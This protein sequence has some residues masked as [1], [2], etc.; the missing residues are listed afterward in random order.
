MATAFIVV[1]LVA[2]AFAR[3][4]TVG[5]TITLEV[6]GATMAGTAID[7]PAGAVVLLISGSGPTDRNGNSR[8]TKNDAMQLIAEGLAARGYASLRYDKRFSG[9]TKLA[10]R[11]ES[12]VTLDRYAE[13]AGFWL[14][15]ALRRYPG[16]PVLPLGHSEGGAVA[17]RLSQL[18]HVDGLVLIAV[19]GR[20]LD[21][22]VIQQMEAAGASAGTISVLGDRLSALR[23]G[24]QIAEVP[25]TLKALLRPGVYPFWRSMLAFDAPTALSGFAGPALLVYGERDLQVSLIDLELF[26]AA[27]PDARSRVFTTMNHVLKSAPPDRAGNLA[28]YQQPDVSLQPGLVSAIADFLAVQPPPSGR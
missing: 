28:L 25:E 5:T 16:R 26:V 12:Q 10:S 20:P 11:A 7:T 24:R 6:P 23:D 19:A 3:S 8:L 14:K 27:K 9:A 17:L 21:R 2:P 15:E 22:L 1:A 18:Q 4:D 13:D